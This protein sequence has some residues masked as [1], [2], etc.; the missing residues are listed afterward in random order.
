[1]ISAALYLAFLFASIVL[2]LIPGPNVALIASTS[3]AHGPRAGLLTVAGTSCA[4]VLQLAMTVAGMTALLTVSANGF[5]AL[6]WMGV[7]YLLYLGIRAWRA[8][9]DDLTA[10]PPVKPARAATFWRGVLVSLTNPKTLLFFGAFLPQ[11][12]SSTSPLLP[13]LLFLSATF[14]ALA[15][16]LDCAWALLAGQIRSILGTRGRVRNRLQGGLLIGA[17]AGLALARKS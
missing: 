12:V 3:I 2:L 11:F 17:A 15:V 14:L 7:F 16:I 13:Q 9:P 10:A 8:A 6:R 4:M 1:M 5:A